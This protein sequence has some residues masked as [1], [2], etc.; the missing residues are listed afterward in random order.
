MNAGTALLDRA[1][2]VPDVVMFISAAVLPL[3]ARNGKTN[4]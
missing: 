1:R 2:G 3:P 4:R